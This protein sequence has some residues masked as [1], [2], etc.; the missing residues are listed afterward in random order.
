MLADVQLTTTFTSRG[1][2][3]ASDQGD[4]PPATVIMKGGCVGRGLFELPL[5]YPIQHPAMSAVGSLDTNCIADFAIVHDALE[6]FASAAVG[7]ANAS[8]RAQ[9]TVAQLMRFYGKT[10]GNQPDS[11]IQTALDDSLLD[12]FPG[13]T[14]DR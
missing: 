4:P 12:M 1:V 2:F 3:V 7:S 11:T 6:G 5:S 8:L 13:L 10:L 14:S 9:R